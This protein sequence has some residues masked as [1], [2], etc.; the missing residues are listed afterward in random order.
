M[1]VAVSRVENDKSFAGKQ[2]LISHKVNVTIVDPVSGGTALQGA[3]AW[4]D[5]AE[6]EALLEYGT[7]PS[8]ADV[9][10][11]TPLMYVCTTSGTKNIFESLE[12]LARYGA[13]LDTVDNNGR[14]AAYYC[15]RSNNDV[16]FR[17][18]RELQ[19]KTAVKK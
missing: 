4:N 7:D 14:D 18:L 5:R 1:V 10:G 15:S 13:R 3:A 9:R 16:A 6:L 19:M 12:L 2:I 11:V 17:Q 8:V